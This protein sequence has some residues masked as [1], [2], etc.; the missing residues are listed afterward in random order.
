MVSCNTFSFHVML[1]DAVGGRVS[2]TICRHL[3]IWAGSDGAVCEVVRVVMMTAVINMP[4]MVIVANPSRRKIRF[5]GWVI[6]GGSIAQ[7][8]R[9]C[10]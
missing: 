3:G 9:G 2:N 10:S 4:M 6:V 5:C 1:R 8:A 7:N